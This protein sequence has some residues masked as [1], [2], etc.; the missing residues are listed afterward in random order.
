MAQKTWRMLFPSVLIVNLL[1]GSPALAQE[2]PE[3]E[4]IT[5][6]RLLHPEDG[7]WLNYRRTYDVQGFSPLDQINKSN[8][9]QLVPIWSY[10][11]RTAPSSSRR[12]YVR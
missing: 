2:R 8:V 3:W 4:M 9:K 7:D 5:S 12:S 11:H 1:T 6:E 10:Y